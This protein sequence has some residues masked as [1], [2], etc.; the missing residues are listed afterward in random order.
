VG[1]NSGIANGAVIDSIWYIDFNNSAI[2]VAQVSAGTT[3]GTAPQVR[4][5]VSGTTIEVQ[6]Q[7]SNGTNRFDGMLVAE[8]NLAYGAGPHPLYTVS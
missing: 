7:S 3:T 2:S 5:N 1:H 4:L 6:V 8:M